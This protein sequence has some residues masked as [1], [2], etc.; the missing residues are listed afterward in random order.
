VATTG[1]WSKVA[2]TSGVWV[3]AQAVK[4]VAPKR[5]A[6]RESFFMSQNPFFP[7]IISPFKK[8]NENFSY[9][10]NFLVQ[11]GIYQQGIS[12]KRDKLIRKSPSKTVLKK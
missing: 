2:A 1:A 9:E 10:A 6:A 12:Q 4:K 7:K 8:A 3:P 11:L 5:R